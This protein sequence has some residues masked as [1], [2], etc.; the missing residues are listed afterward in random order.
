M[1]STI[2]T[3]YPQ[4]PLVV[5]KPLARTPAPTID[6]DGDNDASKAAKAPVASPIAVNTPLPAGSTGSMVNLKA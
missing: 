6:S 5:P 4:A 2:N 3:T 1:S